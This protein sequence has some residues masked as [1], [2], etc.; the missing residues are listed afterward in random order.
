M[1]KLK[2]EGMMYHGL[3]PIEEFILNPNNPRTISRAKMDKLKT[4]ITEFTEMLYLRPIIINKDKVVLGG[5]MR[6]QALKELN[7]EEAPFFMVEDLTPQQEEEF[8][9]KD[10]IGYGEWEWDVLKQEWDTIQLE[11]WGL[12]IPTMERNDTT[13][14]VHNKL[15][16]MFVVP[17]FSVLDTRQGYWKERK[18]YWREMIGDEGESRENL[19]DEG[20]IVSTLNN[21]V[22]ILD[23]VIAELAVRWF[24]LPNSNMFDP[25][26]GDTIFGYVSGY[27][28]N[29]FT[30][31]ELRE[32]QVKL[33]NERCMDISANYICDDAVN[34]SKHLQPSSQDMLFSCPPYYDLE[35]YSELPN[36]ASNQ[37]TYQEFI[38]ILDKAFTD[39]IKLLKDNRFAVIVV[40]DIRDTDGYYRGF[41]DDIKNI[42]I[43]GGMRLYNEMILVEPIGTLPQRVG[44]YMRNRK[45]GKCH[46]NVLVFYK[47]DTNE[48]QN[49]YP[50]LNIVMSDE[51]TNV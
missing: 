1:S 36:D 11:H 12:D 44:R 23:P 35:V 2:D 20:G 37:P 28:G 32:E 13:P 31:I 14:E 40:G 34:I 27:Y 4:S 22:S 15:T 8:I 45:V 24:G 29:T 39:S 6:L 25:F 16:D 21:G 33:N 7:Y 10:N 3:L 41:T 9:I 43:K 50:L 18:Q 51:S 26:A 47:G 46:Q 17:P 49:I 19:L 38:N 30:G 5:N 48:I 42:F